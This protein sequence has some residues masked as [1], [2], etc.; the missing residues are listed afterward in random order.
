MRSLSNIV[1]DRKTIDTVELYQF[2]SDFA[3]EEVKE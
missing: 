2:F 1:K 3:M